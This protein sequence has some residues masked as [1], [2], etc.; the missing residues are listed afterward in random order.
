MPKIQVLVISIANPIL[1]G[2]YKDYEIIQTIKLDGKTTEVLPLAFEEILKKHIIDEIY[3]VNG[4]GSYM[5]IKVAY[6][7][8]KSISIIKNIPLKACDGFEFNQ[9][10]PI[11]AL[12][13]KYFIKQDNN[14]VIQSIDSSMML[15]EFELPKQLNIN[16]FSDDS[17]PNYQLPAV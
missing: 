9:N 1:I 3:Y 12:G 15:K 10:R 11:K 5:A 7:F 13:K 17:L 2:I 8:L 6:V 4:P 14:I 16:K